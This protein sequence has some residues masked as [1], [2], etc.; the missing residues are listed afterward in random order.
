[1]LWF[2]HIFHYYTSL[3]M[4][5]VFRQW[6]VHVFY[7]IL[8]FVLLP[9]HREKK[10]EVKY[11]MEVLVFEFPDLCFIFLVYFQELSLCSWLSLMFIIVFLFYFFLFQLSRKMWLP[12]SVSILLQ[13]L[14]VSFWCT[15]RSQI[16]LKNFSRI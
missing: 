6:C 16:G 12:T 8:F 1:M 5:C 10:G 13:L 9:F 15:C 3:Y 11:T 7:V 4:L 2:G 14:L